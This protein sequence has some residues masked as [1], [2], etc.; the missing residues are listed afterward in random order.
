MQKLNL[1][2]YNFRFKSEGTKEYIFD[3]VRR[4][5]VSMNPEEWVRQNFMQYLIQE[6]KYPES[7][8]AVEK[9]IMLFQKQFRFDL[10]VY[11]RNGQPFLI[12]EFK[13]PDVRISQNTFDQVVRYNMVLRVSLVVIS[14][15]IDHFVCKIDYDSKSYKYLREIPRF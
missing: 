6:K 4:R 13:S 9:Q 14:N 3:P 1:P 15:G 11:N 12:A 10:L 7:L 8:M 2:V 5:F